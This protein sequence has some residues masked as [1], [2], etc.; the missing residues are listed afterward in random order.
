M[1]LFLLLIRIVVG[2]LLFGHGA[3]KLFG[4]FD[5]P[6]VEGTAGFMK[7]LGYRP[8]RAAAVGAGL[9]ETIGGGLLFIGFLTPLAA[10]MIVGGMVNAI[11]SAHWQ[12]GVWVTNGGYELPLT[13]AVTAV[14]VAAVGPGLLSVD[15]IIGASEWGGAAAIIAGTIGLA[16][17]A[18]V[19]SRRTDEAEAAAREL[20]P[21][22]ERA[23]ER[24]AA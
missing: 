9:T 16:V 3:Q 24:R 6:G 1:D 19:L 12:N 8:A 13:Y 17:G 7:S 18:F 20:E 2:G 15:S 14:T 21:E 22:V 4:W 10:A 5:G 11:V 23:E